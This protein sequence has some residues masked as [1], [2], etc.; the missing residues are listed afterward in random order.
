[1]LSVTYTDKM[2]YSV[3]PVQILETISFLGIFVLCNLLKNKKNIMY[4]TIFISA[5]AK[6]LLDFLRFEHTHQKIITENQKFS[7]FLIIITIVIFFLNKNKEKK[8]D[9]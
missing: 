1:M 8:Y 4:I 7:I 2:D 3:F 5:L 9:L 6:F